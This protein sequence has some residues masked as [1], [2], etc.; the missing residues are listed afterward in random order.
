MRRLLIL[1][2]IASM[3]S[4]AVGSTGPTALQLFGRLTGLEQEN[5]VVSSS[6]VETSKSAKES[7]RFRSGVIRSRP[8]PTPTPKPKPEPSPEEQAPEVTVASSDA[9]VVRAD[10]GRRTTPKAPTTYTTKRIKQIITDAA[11]EFGLAPSYLLSVAECESGFNPRAYNDAG[12]YGLFQFDRQ[13]WEAY[14]YGDIYN[15]VAQSRTAARLIAA[16]QEER[17]PNCS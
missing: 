17:W 15:P 5:P 16:G 3:A 13:T 12:Y 10:V 8:A 14:G 2:S 6:G 7:M 9:T 11:N 4:M 1:T